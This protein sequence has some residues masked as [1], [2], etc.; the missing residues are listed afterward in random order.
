MAPEFGQTSSPPCA[1]RERERERRS[2]FD[3]DIRNTVNSFQSIIKAAVSSQST[4]SRSNYPA[5]LMNGERC[6]LRHGARRFT[7]AFGE[8]GIRYE[9][10]M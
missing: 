6:P 4:V 9:S 7:D 2:A 8:T 5:S 10:D 3:S 1:D